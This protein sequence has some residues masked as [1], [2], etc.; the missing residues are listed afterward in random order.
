MQHPDP[1]SNLLRKWPPA[2]AT[3]ES[4]ESQVWTRIAAE[5]SANTGAALAFFPSARAAA[6]WAILFA[7]VAGSSAAYTYDSL[8]R[9]DRMATAHAHLIDPLQLTSLHTTHVH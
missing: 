9:N 3:T 2:P 1:L 4:F 8:T 5:P 6:C 7:S